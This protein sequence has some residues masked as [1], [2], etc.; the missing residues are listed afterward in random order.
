MLEWLLTQKRPDLPITGLVWQSAFADAAKMSVPLAKHPGI[1]M[2]QIVEY[3]VIRT[4]G[5]GS[6]GS[7]NEKAASTIMKV[8][9]KIEGSVL[10]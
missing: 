6:F 3:G 10:P 2:N 9:L 5:T 4:T 7:R 1:T 8:R